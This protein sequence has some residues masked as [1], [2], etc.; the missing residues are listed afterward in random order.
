VT[1]RATAPELAIRTLDLDD[2]HDVELGTALVREYVEFTRVEAADVAGIHIDDDT[3]RRVVTDLT[4]FAG[5]YRTGAY[6]AGSIDDDVAGGVGITR[7][8]DSRCE[9]NRLWIRERFRLDGHG[10]ALVAAC[11][12]DARARGFGE[13]V[14]EVAPFRVRA[15]R[16]Y[17]SFGFR[18]IPPIHEYPFEMLA[19][20]VRLGNASSGGE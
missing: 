10:R 1:N 14:L 8:D 16:L 5:R 15:R 4:D 9:M 12:D 7:L 6:L 18:P 2:P 11:V 17:Q 20:G 19:L 3:I 13:M